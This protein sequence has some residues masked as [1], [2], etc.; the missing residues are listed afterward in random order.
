MK[1]KTYHA[2]DVLRGL[3]ALAVVFWHADV[4]VAPL[5][6]QHG[7]LAV[8]LFF[9]MS[10]FVIAHAYEK[11]FR[12]GL[13]GRGFVLLRLIRLY[14]LYLFGASLG[15]V[16]AIL[17]I[18]G[19][20]SWSTTAWSALMLPTLSLEKGSI[21]YPYNNVAWSLL[22]EIIVN[23]IYAFTWRLWTE[24]VLIVVVSVSAM[25]LILSTLFHGDAN[26]GWTWRTLPGGIARVAFGFPM[27][28]LLYRL[29]SAER[30]QINV[31][32]PLVILAAIVLLAWRP[33]QYGMMVD[34]L[35]LIIVAPAIVAAAIKCETPS[36]AL[37]PAAVLGAASYAVYA[38]HLPLIDFLKSLVG[39]NELG[40]L[41]P[42]GGLSFAA[43]VFLLAIILDFGYDTPVRQWLS[44]R[45][46]HAPASPRQ[47]VPRD[48]AA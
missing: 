39:G 48:Q 4:I 27:G 44:R 24:R 47:A 22:L 19:Q 15:V 35:G 5:R 25:L 46:N 42:W 41:A 26:F 40:A 45:L 43:A 33:E 14:P 34:L 6:P 2:L 11:R 20:F 30:L 28:V 17:G 9:V 7:N 31:R 29:A 37:R 36:W 1:G 10:G 32:F 16:A 38:V 3:A 21:L 12:R 18:G 23:V 8:D 13:S